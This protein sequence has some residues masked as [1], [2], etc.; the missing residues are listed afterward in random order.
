M[1]VLSVKVKTEKKLGIIVFVKINFGIIMP[2]KTARL[3][4]FNVLLV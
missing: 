1:S 4:K 2:M 3:V